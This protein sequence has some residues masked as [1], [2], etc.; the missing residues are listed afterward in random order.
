MPLE[1]PE[2]VIWP[3]RFSMLRAR[4]TPS[5]CITVRSAASVAAAT[6]CTA[7]PSA[8]IAPDCTSRALTAAAGTLMLSR[9]EPVGSTFTALPATSAVVPPGVVIEPAFVTTGPASTTVPPAVVTMLPSL[10]TELD[11]SLSPERRTLPSMN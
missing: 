5:T 1:P 8:V 4:I 11:A 9:P 10:T 2:S 6:S 3:P 7:P